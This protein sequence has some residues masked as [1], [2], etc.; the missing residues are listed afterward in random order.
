MKTRIK[1]INKAI[2]YLDSDRWDSQ[3]LPELSKDD[4]FFGVFESINKL[5]EKVRESNKWF[6]KFERIFKISE[7]KEIDEYDKDNSLENQLIHTSKM[8][9]IGIMATGITHEMTQPLTYLNNYLYTL[10]DDLTTDNTI[11]NNKLRNNL[12]IANKEVNRLINLVNHIQEFSRKDIEEIR[13]PIKFSK[14]INQTLLLMDD[15]I[16]SSN[17]RLIKNIQKDLPYATVNPNDIEQVFI[18]LLQNA[19]D[20]LKEIENNAVLE[21]VIYQKKE[22]KIFC[23]EINDNGK[24]IDKQIKNKIFTPFFTT[25]PAGKGTGLGLNIIQKIIE[26]YG[27]TISCKSSDGKGASFIISLPI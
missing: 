10:Y 19:I 14:V 2:Q 7:L 3:L 25:K 13:I 26:K 17:I 6:H 22:Q 12:E 1:Q 23:I 4:P 9:Q 24:G 8:S 18:N 5:S 11:L 16:Q 21:I 20:S 27:G 15:Q